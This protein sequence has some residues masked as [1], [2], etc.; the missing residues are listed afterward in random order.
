MAR[1]AVRART[2]FLVRS[3]FLLKFDCSLTAEFSARTI[4][5]QDLTGFL[6]NGVAGVPLPNLRLVR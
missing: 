5:Q 2:V 4:V 3:H 6:V 1:E